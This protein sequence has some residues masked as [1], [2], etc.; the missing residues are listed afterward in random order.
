[1]TAQKTKLLILGRS[2]QLAR[3]LAAQ[4]GDISAFE[5]KFLGRPELDVTDSAALE[6]AIAET[7]PDILINA[8]AYTAVDRAEDEPDLAMAVNAEALG[9]MGRA[10][11]EA[12]CPVI[13][14]STDYVFDGAGERPYRPDD[15]TGPRSV[16]GASK[17]AGERALADAQPQHIILRTAWLYSAEGQNFMNTMLRLAETRDSLAVVEDQRG[18]PTLAEDLAEAILTICGHLA[19]GKPRVWGVFHYS[20]AGETTW[21]GF[22]KA[23]FEEAAKRGLPHAQVTPTTTA[24]FG[25][26]APRPAYSVLDGAGLAQAYGITQKEWRQRLTETL[27]SR[28]DASQ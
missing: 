25:A 5:A 4:V 21:F 27:D 17:L 6:R 7:S 15:P 8:T 1:V 26:K 10:A 22:A 16:Y 19:S 24:A 9:V 3:A 28:S 11:A 23:I 12:G 20:G 14:V 2:G 13:H 18:C